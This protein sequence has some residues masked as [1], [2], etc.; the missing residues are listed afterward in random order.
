MGKTAELKSPVAR[1][2]KGESTS[3]KNPNVA[4]ANNI[5]MFCHSEDNHPGL[6]DSDDFCCVIL[7]QFKS[8]KNLTAFLVFT[9]VCYCDQT[10]DQTVYWP[11]PHSL[12]LET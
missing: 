10:S 6:A 7:A 9:E 3:S 1:R 11:T 12:A 8:M 2:G 5:I 4:L